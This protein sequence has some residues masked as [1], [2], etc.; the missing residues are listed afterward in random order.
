MHQGGMDRIYRAI[1]PQLAPGTHAIQ[2]RA[3]D[4]VGHA[5]LSPV[6][7]FTVDRT[8]P[9]I[10]VRGI[11]SGQSYAVDVTPVITIADPHLASASVLLNDRPFESGQMI[12]DEG[13]YQL[14]I[15]ASDASGNRGGVTLAFVL[16]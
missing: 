5:G 10:V 11:T 15:S 1:L 3:V 2:A 6:V 4:A 13:I 9:Q 14:A 16:D 8:A 12:S 7:A